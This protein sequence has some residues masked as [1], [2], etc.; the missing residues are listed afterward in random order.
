MKVDISL[1]MAGPVGSAERAAEL[2]DTGADGLFSFENAHDVFFPLVLATARTAG[3]VDLMTNV[4]MAF[5]RSPLHLAY[6]ANDLQQ[7]N[8]GGFRLGLG[9]QVRP[10]IQKRY[11]S[12][13]D[14][15]AARMREWVLATK[16]IL[17]HSPARA[18]SS[19]GASTRPTR[20]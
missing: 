7:L 2:V 18:R 1:A 8:E 11:G 5:P 9:S 16:M 15:P 4:A 17:D 19:S 3:H 12:P 20:S 14:K 13:W 10:H 6:A